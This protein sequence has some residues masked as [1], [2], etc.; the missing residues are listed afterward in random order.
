MPTVHY[1][2]QLNFPSSNV[3]F[4][5]LFCML[6]TATSSVL[7]TKQAFYIEMY[8]TVKYSDVWDSSIGPN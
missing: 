4:F 3:F 5:R 2:L 6:S 1:L 7:G 8:S